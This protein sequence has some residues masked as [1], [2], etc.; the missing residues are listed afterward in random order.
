M[1]IILKGKSLIL[2]SWSFLLT[3]HVVFEPILKDFS[4]YLARFIKKE[5]QLCLAH[6]LQCL[7]KDTPHPVSEIILHHQ[8]YTST[9]T[10]LDNV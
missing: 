1:V 2:N 10:R 7:Y 3:D 6:F 5:F 8:T 9:E 4:G